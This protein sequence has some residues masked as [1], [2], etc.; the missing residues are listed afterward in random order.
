MHFGENQL[1]PSSIG[2]SPLPAGHPPGL[3]PWWVRASTQ[4]YLSFTLPTG[5][6]PGFGSDARD[7]TPYSDSLSLRPPHTGYPR[8]AR[9]LAASFFKRHAVTS[10]QPPKGAAKPPRLVGTRFQVLFHN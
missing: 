6:S 2:F 1:S 9:Q 8:H 7:S 10:R 3:Q 5:R 4:S